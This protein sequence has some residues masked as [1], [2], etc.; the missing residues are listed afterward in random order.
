MD[1]EIKTYNVKKRE[2]F[3]ALQIVE[4]ALE[5]KKTSPTFDCAHYISNEM[6]S[7]FC[8]WNCFFVDSTCDFSSSIDPYKSIKIEREDYT[9]FIFRMIIK[10]F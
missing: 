5:K 9:I 4:E 10:C 8:G 3:F 1:M 7:E 2:E 6:N